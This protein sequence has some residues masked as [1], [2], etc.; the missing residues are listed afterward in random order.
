MVDQKLRSAVIGLVLGSSESLRCWVSTWN[1][2]K[3]F[4]VTGATWGCGSWLALK[5][6]G[7]L[8]LQEPFGSL[9]PWD[10]LGRHEPASATVSWEFG[11]MRAGWYHGWLGIWSA[12]AHWRLVP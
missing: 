7:N 1:V 3:V 10:L 2:Y 11:D 6:A 12:G 5:Y 4:G 9:V 8:G